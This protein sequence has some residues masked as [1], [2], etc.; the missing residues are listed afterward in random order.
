MTAN[1]IHSSWYNGG[2]RVHD[3]TDS[4]DPEE[5]YSYNPEGYSFWTAVRG[6]GFT[7]GGIYGARSDHD[8]GVA[9]LHADRGQQRA[10]SFEGSAAPADP[11]LGPAEE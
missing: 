6:R 11:G 8:G 2:V 5:L 1:R 3:V 10:P 9:V 7:L 4:S